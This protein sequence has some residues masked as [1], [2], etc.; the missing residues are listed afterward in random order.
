MIES[1]AKQR[2]NT[3]HAAHGSE[4]YELDGF[5]WYADGA[6]RD[7]DL[8]GLLAEP[9]SVRYGESPDRVEYT[10][11]VY[12]LNFFKGKLAVAVRDFTQLQEQLYWSPPADED[13]ALKKLNE[14][15]AVVEARNK[16]LRVAQARVDATNI[17]KARKVAQNRPAAQ[18]ARVE[19]F[20]SKLNKIRV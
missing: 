11:A 4:C 17:G 16:E 12:K 8:L 9:P 19:S 20:R 6:R 3:F 14:L 5:Y 7:V 18:A 2:V 10:L 13:A 15:K 1:L